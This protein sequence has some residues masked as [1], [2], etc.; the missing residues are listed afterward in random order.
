MICFN[1][2]LATANARRAPKKIPEKLVLEDTEF[3]NALIIHGAH[4]PREEEGVGAG[5]Y[6]EGHSHK[7]RP[8][9]A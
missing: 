4:V 7:C 9:L 6:R 8:S 3:Q 2:F 5:L 1:I